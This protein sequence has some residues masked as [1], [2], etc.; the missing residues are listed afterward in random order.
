MNEIASL[1]REAGLDPER[2]D[3]PE[4]LVCAD[5]YEERGFDEEP[6]LLRMEAKRRLIG[7]AKRDGVWSGLLRFCEQYS[8]DLGVM[9]AGDMHGTVHVAETLPPQLIVPPPMP[10][11]GWPPS[12][13]TPDNVLYRGHRWFTGTRTLTFFLL[14]PLDAEG[15]EELARV[16]AEA[17]E[18]DRPI[19][20]VEISDERGVDG[21]IVQNYVTRIG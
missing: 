21:Q 3:V 9:L 16:A 18:S 4:L 14:E 11:L 19:P 13:R 5:W 2:V 15:A 6:H 10:L 7:R 17:I 12:L 1:L 20:D 8:Q